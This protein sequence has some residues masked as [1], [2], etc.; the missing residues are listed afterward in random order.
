VPT[1]AE[2]KQSGPSGVTAIENDFESSA[3]LPVCAAISL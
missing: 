3:E 2:S 1:E